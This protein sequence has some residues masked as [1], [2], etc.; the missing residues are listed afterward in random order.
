MKPCWLPAPMERSLR[1]ASELCLFVQLLQML[2]TLE[3]LWML[4]RITRQRE[5]SEIISG[6]G[7]FGAS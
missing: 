1:A 3:M 4:L 2:K 6:K 7:P 5:Q